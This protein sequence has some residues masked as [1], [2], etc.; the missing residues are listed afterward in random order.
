MSAVICPNASTGC[1]AII[2]NSRLT[3]AFGIIRRSNWSN[4]RGYDFGIFRW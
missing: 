3:I 2:S 4:S 1:I